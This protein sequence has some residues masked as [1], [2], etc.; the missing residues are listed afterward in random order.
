[1]VFAH[2]LFGESLATLVEVLL[3]EF[4]AHVVEAHLVGSDTAG[5]RAH[6]RVE[7][8]VARLGECS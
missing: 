1:M 7:D 4:A 6:H 5:L 8:A 3:V 2:T